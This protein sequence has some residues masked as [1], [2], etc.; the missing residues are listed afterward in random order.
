MPAALPP[1][2]PNTPASITLTV[3][4]EPKSVAAGLTV[5]DLIKAMTLDKGAVAAEVN[6]RLVPKR[7]HAAAILADGDRVELVSLVGGG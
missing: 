1:N 7:E 5:A 6:R 2:T 3:N 4:G